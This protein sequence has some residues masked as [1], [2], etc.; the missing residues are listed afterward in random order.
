MVVRSQF[1]RKLSWVAVTIAVAAGCLRGQRQSSGAEFSSSSASTDAVLQQMTLAAGV[2]FAGQ[3]IAIRRPTGYAGAAEDAA[4]G[5][6][7]VEF[8]VDQAV[9]GCASGPVYTLRE[10]AGL[11]TGGT[12]RYRVGQRL[13]M[14]LHSPDAHGLSST[15]HG[16]EGAIPL[17]GGGAAPGPYDTTAATGDWIVDLRWVQAQAM[18]RDLLLLGRSRR[19]TGGPIP[20]NGGTVLDRANEDTAGRSEVA[21]PWIANPQDTLDSN[22]ETRSLSQVLGLCRGWVRAS[23]AAR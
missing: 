8:R 5:V 20:W 6:V 1:L 4:E 23:D 13:L 19:P 17:R 3:V 21:I 18:R 22:I 2:I 16:A 10:W 12:E 9:R 7:T 11:W 14:F 15:V